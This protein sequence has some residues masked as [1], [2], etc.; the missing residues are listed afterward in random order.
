[1]KPQR[2]PFDSPDYSEALWHWLCYVLILIG[3]GVIYWVWRGMPGF[4]ELLRMAR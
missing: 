4:L 3:A 1:M 2:R